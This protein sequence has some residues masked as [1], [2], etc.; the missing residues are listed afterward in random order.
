MAD[1]TRARFVFSA[2]LL[3][4]IVVGGGTIFWLLVGDAYSFFDSIYFALITVS[5]VG[6]SELPRMELHPVARV[7]VMSMI[8]AGVGAVALFQSSLTAV[9]VE[10]V[11]GRAFRRRRM[12]KRIASLTSH[13]IDEIWRKHGISP[14]A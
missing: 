9:L 1:P 5:T 3:T 6:Y 14:K 8:V 11:I 7:V 13:T 4:V 12:D 10:G 2:A